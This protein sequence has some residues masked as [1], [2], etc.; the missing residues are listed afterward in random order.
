MTFKTSFCAFVALIMAA[1]SSSA[2]EVISI[3]DFKAGVDDGGQFDM[4]L[5]VRS[6][7]EWDTG[8]IPGAIHIPIT[9]FSENEFWLQMEDVG[10]SCDKSCVTIVAHCSVGGRAKIAIDKLRE[11]GFEGT[12]YNGQGTDNWMDAGYGLTM[13]ESPEPICVSNDRCLMDVVPAMGDDNDI[14]ID[15]MNATSTDG[16]TMDDEEDSESSANI[17][18]GAGAALVIPLLLVLL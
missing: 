4:I 13:D 3:E 7:E 15:D 1:G 2:Q 18:F 12:L 14:A 6:Q 17:V 11:M 5:D 9:T 10:Y 8:H 16:M